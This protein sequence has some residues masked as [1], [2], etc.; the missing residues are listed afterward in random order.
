MHSFFV[1]HF[2]CAVGEP[3]AFRKSLHSRCC[4]AMKPGRSQLERNATEL[5]RR[6]FPETQ[7]ETPFGLWNAVLRTVPNRQDQTPWKLTFL[8]ATFQGTY[9]ARATFKGTYRA[10]ATFKGT[11]RALAIVELEKML[12]FVYVCFMCLPSCVC[13]MYVYCGLLLSEA[14]Q[15]E[16][17]PWAFKDIDVWIRGW[18]SFRAAMLQ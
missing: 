4:S 16:Q 1:D 9:R 6:E 5:C 15:A 7:A 17:Q 3:L 13:I 11:Y 10:R 2:A 12:W 14:I 18:L 8:R